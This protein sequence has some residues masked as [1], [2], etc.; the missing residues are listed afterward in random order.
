[1]TNNLSYVCKGL[2][3]DEI[4]MVSGKSGKLQG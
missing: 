2:V 4:M 1:M 3:K